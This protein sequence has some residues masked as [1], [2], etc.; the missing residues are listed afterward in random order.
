MMVIGSYVYVCVCVLVY[1]VCYNVD[2]QYL[3]EHGIS[4]D[5]G[6]LYQD[7]ESAIYHIHTSGQLHAEILSD[8][9][10]VPSGRSNT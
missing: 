2:V 4:Y 7:I 6:N 5:P 9:G 10:E 1:C 3:M 8:L